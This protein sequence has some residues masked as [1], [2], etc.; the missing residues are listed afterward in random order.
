MVILLNLNV[1]CAAY[2]DGVGGTLELNDDLL[3]EL[4]GRFNF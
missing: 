2:D 1:A 4:G 3:I